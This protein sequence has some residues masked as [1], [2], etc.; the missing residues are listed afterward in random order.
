MKEIIYTYIRYF[1][2]GCCML[3][4]PLYTHAQVILTEIMYDITGTDTGREW[5]EVQNVGSTSLDFSTWKLAEANTNHKLSVVGDAQLPS[6]GFAIIVDNVEKFKADN[7]QF[8]G[9]LFDSTFSLSNDGETLVLRDEALADS[10]TV[11]YTPAMGGQGDGTTLQKSGINWISALPTLGSQTTA[12]ESFHP[13]PQTGSNTSNASTSSETDMADSSEA[14]DAEKNTYSSHSSQSTAT[15]SQDIEELQV[16]SG[17]S[18]LGFV[19]A[20]LSFDGHIKSL[21]NSVKDISTTSL[22]GAWSMGDGSEYLGSSLSHT[23]QF[24]G[25]YI[26]IFNATYGDTTAVSKTKVKIVAPEVSLGFDLS[27]YTRISNNSDF[28]LNVG[29]WILESEKRRYILPKDTIIAKKS[30]IKLPGIITKIPFFKEYIHL[31]NPSGLVEATV[32]L[33]EITFKEQPQDPAPLIRL[34]EG[35]SYQ[36]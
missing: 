31:A 30:S 34:F 33:G 11:T 14:S 36:P 18:R 15:I 28:E 5:I 2:T 32:R 23:Y 19:G 13:D 10:D 12:T 22:T 3:C 17:R 26:V 16:T 20:P 8:T 25:D 27:G 7:P 6:Q 24:P 35:L 9:L 21:K 29:G 4:A 1:V